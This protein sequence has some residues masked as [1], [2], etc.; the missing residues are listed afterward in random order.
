MYAVHV[1]C[2][3]L[4][5]NV[6]ACIFVHAFTQAS[7]VKC[8]CVGEHVRHTRVPVDISSKY[9]CACM[10]ACIGIC[11]HINIMCGAHVCAYAC[12]RKCVERRVHV[13]G[14]C[15]AHAYKYSARGQNQVRGRMVKRSKKSSITRSEIY[16]HFLSLTPSG[17]T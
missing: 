9:M 2:M 7:C 12:I 13:P 17:G 10:L 5:T 8:V 14:V 1:M 16:E 6:C 4:R 15:R 3:C 11:V